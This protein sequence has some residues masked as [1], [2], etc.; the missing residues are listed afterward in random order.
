MGMEY[1]RNKV[2]IVTG[3]G[4]GI[5]RALVEELARR[6]GTVIAADIDSARIEETAALISRNGGKINP[7][8]LDVSDFDAVKN[9]VD[10]AMSVH[11]RLDL[12]FNN[13]GIG[14]G[15]EAHHLCLDDW[16]S[17]I[18]INLF[19][20]IHGVQAAYPAMVKQGF[21]QI[22]NTG[23]IEGLCPFP[24]TI[25][26]AACKHAVVGLSST[27]RME[28]ADL[29]VKVSVVCPGHIKT[30]IF[31]DARL[32][33]IDRNKML[34]VQLKLF[35]LTPERA[36][37]VILRGVERNRGIIIVGWDAWMLW[38][39]YRLSPSLGGWVAGKLLKKARQN[40]VFIE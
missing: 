9:M 7:I 27:L 34:D 5:G 36:A 32:V 16:R 35:G 18:A 14:A 31:R 21:G 25:A 37:A 12:I 3:A 33:K 28:G 13:A 22:V 23:S 40:Q 17:V 29:G 39:F 8:T 26:Y 11:G 19:G 6:G 15:G 1:Y 24:G 2:A 30:A 38:L 10:G 4:S 20:V